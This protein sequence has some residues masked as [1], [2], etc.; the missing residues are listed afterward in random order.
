MGCKIKQISYVNIARVWWLKI[1]HIL[2]VYFT[3]LAWSITAGLILLKG[4][5]ATSTT[6]IWVDSICT[7]TV[8][9]ALP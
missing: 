4:I 8:P 5:I 1:T 2:A 9:P 7:N 6:L 3:W